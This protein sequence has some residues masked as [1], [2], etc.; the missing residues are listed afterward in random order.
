MIWLDGVTNSM[1]ISFGKLQELFPKYMEDSWRGDS[2]GMD[3]I[4]I[5]I[6]VLKKFSIF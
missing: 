3:S 5:I 4:L 2:G 6:F 1:V